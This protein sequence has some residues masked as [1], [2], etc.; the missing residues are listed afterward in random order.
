MHF[1]SWSFSNKG[2]GK[3]TLSL[4]ID[5]VWQ[6]VCQSVISNWSDHNLEFCLADRLPW[7]MFL[8]PEPLALGDAGQK[9]C[10]H[11]AWWDRHGRCTWASC[12]LYSHLV[13]L[14]YFL[15]CQLKIR[16]RSWH[17]LH[18]LSSAVHC[19]LSFLGLLKTL[20]ILAVIF[21][22]VQNGN[23]RKDA[24]WPYCILFPA[25][26]HTK[27]WCVWFWCTNLS[28]LQTKGK[29]PRAF[30]VYQVTEGTQGVSLNC[31][32]SIIWK[33]W[34]KGTRKPCLFQL[35]FILDRIILVLNG[36]FRTDDSEQW[37]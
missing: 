13:C 34:M 24:V 17:L 18:V 31:F 8:M 32:S 36:D 9:L 26:T 4:Y 37:E 15:H 6:R 19:L 11:L 14:E 29:A 12:H 25:L 10:R 20:L 7:A 27:N 23:L 21:L 16:K 2:V 30:S 3:M 1:R 35:T 22:T 5:A 28:A 33:G